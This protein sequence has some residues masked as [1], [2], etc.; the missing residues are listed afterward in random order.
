MTL[1][2]I[3]LDS[4]ILEERNFLERVPGRNTGFHARVTR[5]NS[6]HSKVLSVHVLRAL[7]GLKPQV[8]SK[9]NL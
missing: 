5:Q 3:K 6:T 7:A 2:E 8:D 9:K 1:N 4:I